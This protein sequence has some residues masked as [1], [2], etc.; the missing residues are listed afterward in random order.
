MGDVLQFAFMANPP[1]RLYELRRARAWSQQDVADRVRC[2]KMQVSRLERG[3]GEFS[4][5]MMRRFAEVFE[6]STAELLATDDN[7]I[8]LTDDEW[9]LLERL[10]SADPEIRDQLRKVADVMLPWKG[11]ERDAA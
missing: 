10:R 4:L 8:Q 3:V 11:P 1:N 7:P 9:E 5:T 2:S 6:V